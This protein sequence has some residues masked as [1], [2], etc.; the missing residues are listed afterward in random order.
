MRIAYVCA[1][2]GVPV[3][4]QKGCSIHVQEL[5]RALLDQGDQVEL[6]AART[7]GRPPADLA[8]VVVRQLPAPPKGQM[9]TREQAALDANWLLSA[10][11]ELAG[12]YDFVYERYS[13]W[14]YAGMEYARTRGV[15][16][17]LE[18]NA[19]LIEEQA[20]HRTLIHRADAE[21]VA[22]RAFGAASALLAVSAEIAAYLED[23]REARGRIQV[24]PNAINPRRFPPELIAARRPD[25]IRFTIGFLG[26]LKPWHGL[27][28][29]VQ[30]FGL[31]PRSSIE[32]RLRIIGD[33][34]QR[35]ALERD[36]SAS[37]LLDRVEFVGAVPADTVPGQLAGADVGVA[38]YPDLPDFYFSPLKVYEYMATGL[39][40]V[41]SQLGQLKQLIRHETNGLLCPPGDAAALASALDLLRGDLGLRARLGDAARATVMQDHTWDS[42]ARQ[43][44]QIAAEADIRSDVELAGAM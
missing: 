19:P 24:V 44:V 17:L 12:P 35:Q 33:G 30:A 3:F 34:P 16:G 28:T 10:A 8:K 20:R 39:P 7:D 36:L 27:E 32:T 22:A 37:G 42:V 2:P 5:I 29:L 40:V 31:L 1:D 38:P 43:V 11:L 25:P 6:F 13:L 23:R 9:A 18:V 15:P 41:V 4:G 14:S 21:Q 26:T